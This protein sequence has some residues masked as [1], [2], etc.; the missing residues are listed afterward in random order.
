M[1]RPDQVMLASTRRELTRRGVKRHVLEEQVLPSDVTPGEMQTGEMPWQG[2]FQALETA[3]PGLGCDNSHVTVIVSNHFVRYALI[4]WSDALSNDTEEM[5]FA[6]HSFREMYGS[7]ADSWELRINRDSTGMTQLACA[8]D[9]R[10]LDGLRGLFSRAGIGLQSIQPHLMDAYNSNR[11]ALRGK[12][13]W[14]VIAERGNTCLVLLRDGQWSWVRTIRTGAEWRE[15]LPLLLE[16]E[17]LL[18]NAGFATDEVFL[19]APDYPDD[20]LP[21]GSRWQFQCLHPSVDSGAAPEQ[22]KQ[23]AMGT[24]GGR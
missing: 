15:E 13:A 19:W 4:P 24:D 20:V 22:G 8:V 9:A 5:A 10:L 18:A 16:R 23:S 7:D 21:S 6:Q 12:S 17:E 1:L 2:S 11:A 3:L 14:L